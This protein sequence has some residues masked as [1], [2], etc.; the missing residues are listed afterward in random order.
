[1]TRLLWEEEFGNCLK[2]G[3]DVNFGT[4]IG[5]AL[6]LFPYNDPRAR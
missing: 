1:M 6:L 4:E 5:N 2:N 3:L